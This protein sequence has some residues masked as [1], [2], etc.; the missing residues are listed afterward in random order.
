MAGGFGNFA[1][2]AAEGYDQATNTASMANYRTQELKIQQQA[3]QN[4]QQR[5]QYA[6]IDKTRT[7]MWSVITDTIDHAKNAGQDNTAI[8]QLVQPLIQPLKKLAKSS[9]MDDTIYDAQL[10]ALLAKPTSF[11]VMRGGRTSATTRAPATAAT[12]TGTAPG[13]T[14]TQSASP[15]TGLGG[16]EADDN[17]IDRLTRAMALADND[18]GLRQA[19]AIRLG[20]AFKA[21][22]SDTEVKTIKDQDGN[23]H[24]LF[25]SPRRRTVTDANG[26]P[27]VPPS[28]DD[29]DVHQI[30][31]AI[32]EGRQ[33]PTTTGLYRNA[34]A[35]R[36]D[37]ERSGFNLTTANLEYQSAQQ[38]VKSLNAPQM[39][40]YA[41]LA[42][43]VDN[44]IDEVKSLAEQMGNSGVPL[45]N[46]VKLA[47][48]IQTA[49]NTQGGQLAAKYV[50]AVNT[51]KEEFTNLAQGGYAPTESAWALANQQINA[52][53]GVKE[54]NASLTEV[55]RLIR[56]RLQGIP[57]FQTLG[58]GS[59]TNRYVPG[60][61]QPQSGDESG[62]SSGMSGPVKWKLE[63]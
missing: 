62:G 51:L 60:G 32:R 48:Y 12:T 1:G 57:N 17:E 3:Q 52:D 11:D 63:Q 61:G 19:L 4:A 24:V 33:P 9:G 59:S 21:Q 14:G 35:V 30:S 27:Y 18:S 29:S 40:R 56:Y 15:T 26:N 42:K 34:K 13:Q 7:E 31:N 5:D 44:T 22:G 10:A 46:K 58:P 36:A 38:Q 50:A 37:L 8:A 28:A 16:P 47:A 6:R 45:A 43:S 54:L 53:Y 41:G 20:E 2:G 23:E 49:G 25:V 39:V 55:Q